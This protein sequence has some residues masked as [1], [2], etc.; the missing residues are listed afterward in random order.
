MHERASQMVIFYALAKAGSFTA[1]AKQMG[2]STSH[3]SKQ[4]GALE[5]T[6]NVKLV[7]RTTRSLTLTDAG[8]QFFLYCEKVYSAMTEASAIMDDERDEVTGILR[9]GLS[10]SFGTMHII[11]AIDKLRHQYPDLQVEVRLFDHRADM[12]KDGLDLWVTNFEDLPEGYVAQRLADSNFVLAASPD[13]LIDKKVPHHPLDLVEHN[14]LTYQ[15]RHRDYSHWDFS[16]GNEALCVK[17]SGNYRVDLAEAVRDAAISGWGI[18]YLA[19]YLLTNEFNDGKLIQLLPDWKASQKMP[20]YAVYPSRKHLPRKISAVIDFLRE[21]IGQ[22]PYW[23]K[24][25][26]KRVKL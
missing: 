3:V 16:K 8:Q 24:A 19:S 23:D 20:I 11:P 21:H 4:L 12:L 17:V 26:M 5:E 1:A 6:L 13:Y 14:C 9:L 22:P 15:S 25:L 2:V 18:A 10:Q 7:H